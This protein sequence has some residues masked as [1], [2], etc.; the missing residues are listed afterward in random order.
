MSTVIGHAIYSF[1]L[2]GNTISQSTQRSPNKYRLS[3]QNGSQG[4]LMLKIVQS[5]R[6]RRSPLG[7]V[8]L[9]GVL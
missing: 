8:V 1:G 9:I 7:K 5:E 6:W 3:W 2:L 4:L